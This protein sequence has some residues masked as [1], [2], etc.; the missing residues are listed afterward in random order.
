MNV[1]RDACARGVVERGNSFT[2]STA[3]VVKLYASDFRRLEQC[4]LVEDDGSGASIEIN[5]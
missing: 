1:A 4:G 3:P 5:D 2:M